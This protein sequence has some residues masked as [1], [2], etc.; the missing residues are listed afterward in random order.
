MKDFFGYTYCA[1]CNVFSSTFQRKNLSFSKTRSNGQLMMMDLCTLKE[2]PFIFL[3]CFH[4]FICF[5]GMGTNYS[6]KWGIH[7][8]I[9]IMGLIL[10]DID[11]HTYQCLH[12]INPSSLSSNSIWMKD[13]EAQI[14]YCK[15]TRQMLCIN[16]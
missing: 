7:P 4:Y 1:Q 5:I 14:L 2:I 11:I 8:S 12:Y 13:R 3:D 16:H 9:S 6:S 10:A 15:S